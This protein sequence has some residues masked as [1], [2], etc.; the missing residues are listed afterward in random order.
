MLIDGAGNWRIFFNIYLPMSLPALGTQAIFSFSGAWDEFFTAL[1]ILKTESKRTLPIA[2]QLFQGQHASDW[3][4]VFAA[5]IIAI[6][7][8]IAIY[9]VFQK[10]FVQG[11]FNEGAIKG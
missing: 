3:G 6:I 9:I 1:T 7:P 11:G 5:S 10:H 4:L 8:I 2:L